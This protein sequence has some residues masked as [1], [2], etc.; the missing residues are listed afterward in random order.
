MDDGKQKMPT[1]QEIMR[2]VSAAK[3]MMEPMIESLGPPAKMLKAAF[4]VLVREGFTE[5]QALEIIK[6]RGFT[7]GGF[8]E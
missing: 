2:H 5:K 3:K 6:A 8:N 7:F 1:P 4:D